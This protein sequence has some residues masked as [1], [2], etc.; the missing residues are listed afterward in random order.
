METDYTD[1]PYNL[2][3]GD[4][5]EQIIKTATGPET[6]DE[7]ITV[8]KIQVGWSKTDGPSQ[9]NGIHF[10]FLGCLLPTS[11]KFLSLICDH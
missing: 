1:N 11:G 3:I 10:R 2:R 6:L 7:P 4:T 9:A 5:F 8:Q